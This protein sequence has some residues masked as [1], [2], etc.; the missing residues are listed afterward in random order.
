MSAQ[1]PRVWGSEPGQ[2]ASL[3]RPHLSLLLQRYMC[4]GRG[5]IKGGLA[6]PRA[7]RPVAQQ[8][9]AAS[10]ALSPSCAPLQGLFLLLGIQPKRVPAASDHHSQPGGELA[11][12]LGSMRG[13]ASGGARAPERAENLPALLLL[14]GPG[15]LRQTPPPCRLCWQSRTGLALDRLR[16]P[17]GFSS[18]PAAAANPRCAALS[19]P[20]PSADCAAHHA[21]DRLRLLPGGGAL[22][23]QV[24]GPEGRPRRAGL[25]Q[26]RAMAGCRGWAALRCRGR[27]VLSRLGRPGLPPSGRAVLSRPGCA[28]CSCAEKR[29]L[30][31]ALHGPLP[32]HSLT[33]ALPAPAC[34]CA[35]A[36][37][38]CCTAP[39]APSLKRWRRQISTCIP[40]T[41]QSRRSA[42]CVGSLGLYVWGRHDPS[43]V[44][45]VHGEPSSAV[46][47]WTG[48]TLAWCV[49][50][51]GSPA[52]HVLPCV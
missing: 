29:N 17:P 23:V 8:A 51:V 42:W 4:P 35:P 47:V 33:L 25:G 41:G 31:A 37:G 2:P 27:A 5:A 10:H 48:T 36:A 18:P 22:G 45:V 50:G 30:R 28:A 16:L 38:R 40:C 11:G 20:P 19:A 21:L 9:A 43:I 32:W 24:G 49:W 34:V 52:A 14:P 26:A 3:W 13:G 12:G 1:A 15:A 39:T 46:C 6:A 44:R 7:G